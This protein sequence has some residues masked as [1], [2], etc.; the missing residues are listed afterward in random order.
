MNRLLPPHLLF[1]AVAF[2][3]IPSMAAEPTLNDVLRSTPKPANAV[4]HA[5]LNA[6]HRL[7]LGTPMEIELPAN[8]DR[9]RI[10]CE[11]DFAKLQPT[12]E[13]GYATMKTIP[14]AETV[15]QATGG[16]VEKVGN[17]DVVWT[18]NQM[19]LVPLPDR[20]LSIVRPADRRFLSQWLRRDRNPNSGDY[21]TNAAGKSLDGL[22]LMIAVDV[23][24]LIAPQTISETLGTF[25]SLKGKDAVA[26]ANELANLQG[27]TLEVSRDTLTRTTITLSF[28]ESPKN[29]QPIAKDFFNELL[30]RRGS[31]IKDFTSWTMTADNQSKTLQFRGTVDSEFLDDILG[32]FTVQRQTAEI[33][34]YEKQPRAS[35]QETSRSL[36]AENSREYFK[37]VW[38]IVR[39]VRDYS[40]SN[41]GER[42][43]WNGNMANRIDEIPTLNVD[44]ELVQ[45]GAEVGKAL[46]NNMVSMQLTNIATGAQAVAN[47]AGAPLGGGVGMGVAGA[48]VGGFNGFYSGG[49]G[50]VDNT[51]DPNSPLKYHSLGQ[52]QGNTNF[53][54]MIAD[55]EQSIADM[56]RR[57]TEKYS[58]QF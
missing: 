26:V 24:D 6:L 56:R 50:Y 51:F 41:T 4:M 2:C 33:E 57:M 38:A 42:A 19:Y 35:E 1:A 15:A 21:L 7:T 40:A 10:A 18:P 13:I 45:F 53:R 9:V 12:W 49:M 55:L 22:S 32:V 52:A 3:S 58:I 16:Y 17:R 31:S 23:E 5:D 25:N 20:V 29:L 39:R 28:R 27:V 54:Q 30:Q 37:K 36:I 34:H 11:I 46:R 47:N 43:Q 44:S 48:F 8:I 14:P